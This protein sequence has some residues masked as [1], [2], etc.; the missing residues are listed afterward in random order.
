MEE[1]KDE[2]FIQHFPAR[3]K[4]S[5]KGE[6][7]RVIVVGGSAVY[8][9]APVHSA[10]GAQAVG[11]DL[12]YLALPKA[13]VPSV[14]SMSPD[15][16]VFPLPDYKLTRGSA[17]RLLNW[18]PQVDAAV[19]GPGLEKPTEEGLRE[20]I[21]EMLFRH[22]SLVLDAGA[23]QPAVLELLKGKNVILTPHAGEFKRLTGVELPRALE[24]RAKY[25]EDAARKLGLVLVQKGAGDVI[26]DGYQTYLNR[27]GRAAMT[28]GGTGDVLAGVAAALLSLKVPPLQAAAMA[29]YVN[30]IAG[31]KVWRKVGNR[32]TAEMLADELVHV[33][34]RF[35]KE[36][37]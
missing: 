24:D 3:K 9:G 14:R 20:L 37:V 10:R 29:A 5:R 15:F 33:M 8:H 7:G 23:L 34:K 6:N 11:I 4:D 12:L 17:R 31:T 13:I 21:K 36:D 32:L 19:I 2:L 18:L 27:T 28:A 35:D 16:I 30:G 1:T 22:C 26:T 25:V